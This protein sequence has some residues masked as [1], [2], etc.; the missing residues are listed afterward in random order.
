MHPIVE[1]NLLFV[2]L[3]VFCWAGRYNEHMVLFVT[4]FW[5]IVLNIWVNVFSKNN[6]LKMT[7]ILCFFFLICQQK[8]IFVVVVV[9]TEQ[10]TIT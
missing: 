2:S 4:V 6:T 10:Y 9:C 5:A 3:H 8:L 1:A 7:S